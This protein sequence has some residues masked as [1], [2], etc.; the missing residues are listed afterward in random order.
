MAAVCAVLGIQPSHPLRH[1][2]RVRACRAQ[3]LL[4]W[5]PLGLCAAR[6][7][8]AG[9]GWRNSCDISARGAG[10]AVP[11]GTTGWHAG[12]HTY[13]PTLHMRLV[14]TPIATLINTI[15]HSAC[16]AYHIDMTW[17]TAWHTAAHLTAHKLHTRNYCMTQIPPQPQP[18]SWWLGAGCVNSLRMQLQ[19]THW[20]ACLTLAVHLWLRTPWLYN[21]LYC[22]LCCCSLSC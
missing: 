15:I 20:H 19:C 16:F 13:T 10:V 8:Q 4:G 7:R 2:R 21:T 22:I 18:P 1:Q 14:C 6:S 5:S 12:A 9:D 17:R 11:P 3:L